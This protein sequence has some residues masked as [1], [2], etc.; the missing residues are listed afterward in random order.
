[1]KKG[2]AAMSLLH[3]GRWCMSDRLHMKPDIGRATVEMHIL[4]WVAGR[5]ATRYPK[6]RGNP[7]RWNVEQIRILV[8]IPRN[9]R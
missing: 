4:K 6:P 7:E 8:C 1:M 9:A 5:I 3:L 2:E